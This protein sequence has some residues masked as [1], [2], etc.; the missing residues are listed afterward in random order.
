MSEF[1]FDFSVVKSGGPLVTI[2]NVGLSFNSDVQTLLGNPDK[3]IIGFD[4]NRCA[5]GV[6]DF[7]GEMTDDK[8]IYEFNSR[9]DKYGWIRI[10]MRDFIKYLSK[11]S[12]MSFSPAIR[13][14]P[15]YDEEKKML[16]I[17]VDKDHIKGVEAGTQTES[18]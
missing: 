5:I 15:D 2:N 1:N 12:G 14:I 4:K 7:E 10:S 6:K 17:M 9:V 3:I 11:V 13:F 16:I 8:A 18:D